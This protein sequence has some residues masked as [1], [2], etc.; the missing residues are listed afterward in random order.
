MGFFI[1][2]LDN[3]C[4]P[5]NMNW[6]PND[7]HFSFQCVER[8]QQRE[9]HKKIYMEKPLGQQFLLFIHL[10]N[11]CALYAFFHIHSFPTNLR[12][13]FIRIKYELIPNWFLLFFSTSSVWFLTFRLFLYDFIKMN[14]SPV[15]RLLKFSERIPFL[16]MWRNKV[17]NF[18]EYAKEQEIIKF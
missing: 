5:K 9:R 10:H 11:W 7:S 6:M 1:W 13:H 4:L 15:N 3:V 12:V 18:C 8:M 17:F 2:V 16:R 14:P